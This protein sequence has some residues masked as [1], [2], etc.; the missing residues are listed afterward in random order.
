MARDVRAERVDAEF[1]IL[2]GFVVGR[3]GGLPIVCQEHA[4]MYARAWDE[5]PVPS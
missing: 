3:Q 4:D 1:A 2:T 5:G